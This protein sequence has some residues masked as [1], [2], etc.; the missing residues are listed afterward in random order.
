MEDLQ[1]LIQKKDKEIEEINKELNSDINIK[2]KEE[3]LNIKNKLLYEKIELSNIYIKLGNTSYI[4]TNKNND[5][6]N[7]VKPR[8]RKKIIL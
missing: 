2:K 8:K 1:N 5:I 4:Q 7:Q 6:N 3:L